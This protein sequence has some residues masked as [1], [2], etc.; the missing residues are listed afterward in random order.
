M[1]QNGICRKE[2]SAVFAMTACMCYYNFVNCRKGGADRIAIVNAQIF[3][4]ATA[5]TGIAALGMTGAVAQQR[6]QPIDSDRPGA[7][8]PPED[9]SCD[10]YVEE[11]R[12]HL[13]D[14]KAQQDWRYVGKRYR[15]VESGEVYD[16]TMWLEWEAEAGC[17]VAAYLDPAAASSSG[18]GGTTALVIVGGLLTTAAIAAG[19]SGSEEVKSPG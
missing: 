9:W 5:L 14:G 3:K 16:W 8:Q 15:S 4:W 10:L 2:D 7:L 1:N 6:A 19:G 13:G 18:L 12:E 17:P 11:Y